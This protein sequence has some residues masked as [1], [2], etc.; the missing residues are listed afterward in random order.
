VDTVHPS[1]FFRSKP[2]YSTIPMSRSGDTVNRRPIVTLG[3]R[4][5]GSL[6]YTSFCRYVLSEDH[7]ATTPHDI[8]RF[9]IAALSLD[10]YAAGLAYTAGLAHDAGQSAYD[11]FKDYPRSPGLKKVT[12]DASGFVALAPEGM[13][14]TSQGLPAAEAAA[15]GVLPCS[16]AFV[17]RSDI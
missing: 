3:S 16:S 5:G 1:L 2:K 10:D 4:R 11:L 12:A 14:G 8:N 13:A 6:I 7:I 9:R 15:A 17:V